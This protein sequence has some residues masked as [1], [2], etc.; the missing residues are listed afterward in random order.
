MEPIEIRVIA[1]ITVLVTVY[2]GILWRLGKW[3]W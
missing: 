1:I 3:K 2:L